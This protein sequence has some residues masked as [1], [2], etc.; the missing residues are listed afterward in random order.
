LGSG[1]GRTDKLLIMNDPL[2]KDADLPETDD[3]PPVEGD[4]QHPPL[5]PE[6]LDDDSGEAED[7]RPLPVVRG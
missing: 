6:V 5:E 2:K 4:E 1:T 7:T 3:L